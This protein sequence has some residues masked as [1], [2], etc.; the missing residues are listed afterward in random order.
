MAKASLSKHV[1]SI[2]VLTSIV[3]VG[4]AVLGSAETVKVIGQIE[5]TYLQRAS[6]RVLDVV[7]DASGSAPLKLGQKVS[8]QL[9]SVEKKNRNREIIGYGK[10]YEVVLEGNPTTEYA[11]SS[12]SAGTGSSQDSSGAAYMWTASRIARVKDAG[13][14][15]GESG[16]ADKKHKKGKKK[17]GGEEPEKIWTQEETVRGKVFFKEKRVYIKDEALRPR[18]RGLDV[19]NDDW[20]EKLKPYDGRVVVVHG[21][22]RRVTAAS[23][24]IDIANLIKI[25]PK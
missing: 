5:S 25:Y 11:S 22:T 10:V 17:K 16:K 2:F 21:T 18:D 14:Y 12:L 24:T 23:G 9:P 20:Y 8:F 4:V 6:I 19:L 1:L 7:D 13:K 15:L 3:V